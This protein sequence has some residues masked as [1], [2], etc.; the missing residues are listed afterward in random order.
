MNFFDYFQIISLTIMYI[1]LIVRTIQIRLHG[2]KVWTLG[3]NKKGVQ[4]I[5]EISFFGG[6]IIWT[7][8]I[9]LN[10]FNVNLGY[11]IVF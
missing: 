5:L 6:L 3:K 11:Y 9:I 4:R 7:S 1:L 8:I 2:I 10:A